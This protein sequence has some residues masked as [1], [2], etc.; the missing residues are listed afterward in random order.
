MRTNDILLYGF[1]D[2]KVLMQYLYMSEDNSIIVHNCINWSLKIRMDENCQFKCLNM[3]FP[4]L[5]ESNWSDEMT[6]PL[7]LDIIEKL[8]EEPAVE[9]KE[10]FKNRWEELKEITKINVALNERKQRR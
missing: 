2:I 10:R 9:F 4:H 3:N 1:E 6:I 7:M 5:P 8:K